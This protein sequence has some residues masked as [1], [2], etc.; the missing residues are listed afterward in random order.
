MLDNA[1]LDNAVL[2]NVYGKNVIRHVRKTVSSSSELPTVGE[3]SYREKQLHE[4][5]TSKIDAVK[6]IMQLE[7]E[8]GILKAHLTNKL[9]NT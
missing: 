2:D 4:K 6:H 7:D 5:F 8:I 1:V 3:V 9:T